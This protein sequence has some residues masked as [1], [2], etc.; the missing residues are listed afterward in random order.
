MAGYH[1]ANLIAQ[2]I[3][4]DLQLLFILVTCSSIRHRQHELQLRLLLT[5]CSDFASC[6][7][8][9]K[10]QVVSRSKHTFLILLFL[11]LPCKLFVSQT[12]SWHLLLLLRP[13][14]RGS[15]ASVTVIRV[16]QEAVKG[17]RQQSQTLLPIGQAIAAGA[18]L[19]TC[20]QV[21]SVPSAWHGRP[22]PAPEEPWPAS[23]PGPALQFAGLPVM[24]SRVGW[25]SSAASSPRMLTRCFPCSATGSHV[26][27]RLQPSC[28]PL[29]KASEASQRECRLL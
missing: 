8:M 14:S 18:L 6:V 17:N 4:V 15:P 5:C 19:L 24:E 9:L 1:R 10:H 26:L 2:P 3:I 22:S 20:R 25:I 16:R 11:Q 7:K 21:L 29:S 13:L 23:H 27:E 12:F 28:L